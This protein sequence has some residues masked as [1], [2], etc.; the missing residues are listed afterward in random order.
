MIY[1]IFLAYNIYVALLKIFI[2]DHELIYCVVKTSH[3]W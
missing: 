2:M 3:L 1:L